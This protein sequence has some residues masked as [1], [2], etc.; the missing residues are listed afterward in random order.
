MAST[1]EIDAQCIAVNADTFYEAV[2]RLYSSLALLS[3]SYSDVIGQEYLC[4]QLYGVE[5]LFRG[6]LEMID[7]CT[8]K[9][10]SFS[11][12]SLNAMLSAVS[13]SKKGR[14]NG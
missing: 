10:A 13:E 5:V 9:T 7:G 4:D 8:V 6:A 2:S 1:K 12:T 3:N 14:C 11:V